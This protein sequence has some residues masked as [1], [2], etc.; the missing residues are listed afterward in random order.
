LRPDCIGDRGL[1]YWK[2]DLSNLFR[3]YRNENTGSLSIDAAGLAVVFSFAIGAGIAEVFAGLFCER[4]Q[5]F[6]D[7]G[8]LVGDVYAFADVRLKIIQSEAGLLLNVVAGSAAGTWFVFQTAIRMRKMQFPFAAADGVQVTAPVKEQGFVRGF[9]SFFAA[10]QRPD[11]FAVDDAVLRN[12][13]AREICDG[14]E[15]VDGHCHLI[16]DGACRDLSGP[17][18]D[19]G[20]ALSAVPG[21]PF[22]FAEW[23]CGAGVIAVGEPGAV[24]GGEDDQRVFFEAVFFESLTNLADGPVDFHDHIAVESLL[25][26]AFELIADEQRDVGHRVRDV[27]KERPVTT[28]V[29]ERYG[30]FGIPGGE[31]CL[32]FAGDFGVNHGFVFDQ[33]EIGK[34][35]AGGGMKGPHIVGVGEPEVFI[36]AVSGGEELGQMAKV[37][38]TVDGGI[39]TQR[40]E[41]FGDG[42]FV[43][44]YPDF[45]LGAEC[46]LNSDT[47]RIA[48]GEQ[49]GSGSRADGLSSV[50]VGEADAFFGHLIEIRRFDIGRAEDADI[51]ITLVVG[52]DN[53]EVGMIFSRS[54]G[55]RHGLNRS[56]GDEK[57]QKTET[58][59]PCSIQIRGASKIKT[60][61]ERAFLVI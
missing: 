10:H 15:N 47:I 4:G 2:F 41:D 60:G 6:D 24:V 44:V 58:R 21:G 9:G 53:H 51:L 25:G 46:A 33:R 12:F 19:A 45:R 56:G 18:H 61:H 27:E 26:F 23:Q 8:V 42:G 37:P 5:A 29:D 40:F 39:V 35:F 13:S 30:V 38:F 50:E 3:R 7:V 34:P 1:I 55:C 11:I 52:E 20:L 59:H 17:G 48:A 43:R 31:L 14:G 49:S 22:A 32:F 28:F 36:E 57:N 16:A 54:L